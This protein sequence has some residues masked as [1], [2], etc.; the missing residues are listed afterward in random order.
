MKRLACDK[1]QI[2]QMFVCQIVR[3]LKITQFQF[4]HHYLCTLYNTTIEFSVTFFFLA[5][6]WNLGRLLMERYVIHEWIFGIESCGKSSI[7]NTLKGYSGFEVLIIE[8]RKHGRGRPRYFSI[9][10]VWPPSVTRKSCQV[11]GYFSNHRE[12]TGM[13]YYQDLTTDYIM[14]KNKRTLSTIRTDMM[15]ELYKTRGNFFSTAT[16]VKNNKGI[17]MSLP[18]SKFQQAK[19]K[20]NKKRRKNEN[21]KNAFKQPT[22]SSTC[23]ELQPRSSQVD[24]VPS[25]PVPSPNMDHL[26][27]RKSIVRYPSK[28][29]WCVNRDVA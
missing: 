12:P 24:F 13:P 29:A 16:S 23:P 8:G 9:I 15:H 11:G 1:L 28:G 25:L 14:I 2:F 18:K 7:A 4:E 10:D 3:S 17:V 21:E 5:N 27:Q 19:R 20:Q 22:R 26:H 6:G